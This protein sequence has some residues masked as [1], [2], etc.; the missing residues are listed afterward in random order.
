MKLTQQT[1]GDLLVLRLDGQLMGG[2][3]A[4]AV[5]NAI[6]SAIQQG[7]TRILIDMGAVSWVNS[8]GLGILISSHMAAR[9][10]GGSLKLFGVSKRIDSILAVTRLNTVFEVLPAEAEARKSFEASASRGR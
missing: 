7:I 1:E 4:E 6:A 3:D 2:P 5:R 9:Q 8:S 10:A